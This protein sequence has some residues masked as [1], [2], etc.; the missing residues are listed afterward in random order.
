MY[1][2]IVKTGDGLTITF[3][4]LTEKK[5]AEKTL[6]HTCHELSKAQNRLEKLNKQ[7]EFK[8]NER[9]LELLEANHNLLL[10]KEKM[11]RINNN[12]S[13]KNDDLEKV[14]VA[15]FTWTV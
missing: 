14:N 6:K 15:L 9:T 3:K 13:H 11:D 12:L 2:A 4:D 8:V 10:A 1:L 5:K 7:L